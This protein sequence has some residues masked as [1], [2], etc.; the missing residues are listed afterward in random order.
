VV[1]G[2]H[3]LTDVIGGWLLGLAIGITVTLLAAR[4][5]RSGPQETA[6]VLV[7]DLMQEGRREDPAAG[8]H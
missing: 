7:A 1:V 5:I 4:L 2:A 8:N 6:P 3:W